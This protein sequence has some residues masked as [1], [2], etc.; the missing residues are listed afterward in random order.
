LTGLAALPP[1]GQIPGMDGFDFIAHCKPGMTLLTGDRRS[2]TVTAVDA[3]AGLVHGDLQMFGPTS[4][5]ADGLWIDAPCG[6]RGLFD[7]AVPSSEPALAPKRASM[8]EALDG[9]NRNFC[10]D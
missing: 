5:R 10:C 9:D 6:A 4:W 3:A 7:L 2:V 8:A 1:A